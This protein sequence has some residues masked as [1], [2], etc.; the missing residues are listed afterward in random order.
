[1]FRQVS[2]LARGPSGDGE[3]GPSTNLQRYAEVRAALRDPVT[4]STAGAIDC[5]Q[6]RPLLPLQADPSDHRRYRLLLEPVFAPGVISALE[7]LVRG[8]A[9]HLIHKFA[10]EGAVDFNRE[11]SRPFPVMVLLDFLDLPPTDLDLLRALHEMIL[12]PI[13]PDDAGTFRQEVGARIYDYFAPI[14]A[15]RRGQTGVGLI[16]ALQNACVD[17]QRLNDDEILDI[18]YLLLLAGIDPVAEALSCTVAFLAQHPDER[19]ALIGSE[20]ALRRTTEELLRWG[21]SVKVL[22][23]VITRE[24]EIAGQTVRAGERIG[25]LLP[26]ANRDPAAFADP[27]HVDPL[28]RDVAHLAFGAGPHR[29]IGVHLARLE[30]R[31]ALEEMQA[32]IPD[33]RLAPSGMSVDAAVLGAHEALPL[34]FTRAST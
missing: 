21:S 29:C 20:Q 22:T 7:P 23:R 12:G 26:S 31:V 19:E 15:G 28:R 5:G 34:V 3:T 16:H 4:F 14:V 10:D 24:V 33:Y 13:P 30:L 27:D 32:C 11:F 18:C 1:M 8:R 9:R 17:G 2:D 6:R 25:C